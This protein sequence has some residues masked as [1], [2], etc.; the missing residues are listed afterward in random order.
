MAGSKSGL[1]YSPRAITC[2]EVNRDM[3]CS[4]KHAL[5]QRHIRVTHNVNTS[6]VNHVQPV[7]TK[8]T[9][10]AGKDDNLSFVLNAIQDVSFQQR[11]IPKDR[12][13]L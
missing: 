5:L 13:L 11:S 1:R 10:M 12:K 9:T 3:S 8:A 4:W 7:L 6:R 2:A